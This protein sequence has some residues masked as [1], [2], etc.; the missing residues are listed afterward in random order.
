MK[1][2]TRL[3]NKRTALL[4]SVVLYLL[5]ALVISGCKTSNK[6]FTFYVFSDTH[7]TG[8]QKRFLINDSMITEANNLYQQAFPESLSNRKKQKPKGVLICG[9]LTDGATEK[10]WIDFTQ[11][12]GMNGENHLKYPVYENHGNHDGD[13]V[14]VV[15][16]GIKQ[17]NRQRTKITNV[18]ENGLHYSF[19]WGNY[20]FVSLGSY[21]ANGW[22]ST[23]GW[24]HY[25][26]EGFRDPQNSLAFLQQDLAKYANS[27][28]KVIMYFHYGWDDFSKL[29]WTEK[30]QD[31]FYKVIK[32]YNIACIFSGHDHATGCRNWKGINVYS[33]GS[34]QHD[35]QTGSFLMVQATKDSMYVLEREWNKWGDHVYRNAVK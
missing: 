33:A 29:W 30:E 24:C 2:S 22:D 28:T 8:D 32:N 14:G 31:N 1:L 7:L 10:Q 26:K 17:R 13:S 27:R 25:F 35:Q 6:A 21:P 23:C 18:S 11:L 9:D 15:R 3:L 34:P 20:H 16:Q 12:Y 5:F 19:D 4:Y